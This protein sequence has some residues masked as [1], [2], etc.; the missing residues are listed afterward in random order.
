MRGLTRDKVAPFYRYMYWDKCRCD[1][2]PSG[3]AYL[4]FDTAVNMG[5]G[6]A[7]KLLQEAVGA[8]PDGVVGP[9]TIAVTKALDSYAVVTEISFLRAIRYMKTKNV[10]TF[11]AGWANRLMRVKD[12]AVDA[13]KNK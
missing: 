6:A 13:S 4:V 12:M 9:A 11:G 5:V 10:G 1:S 3:V 2:L 8:K 7:S